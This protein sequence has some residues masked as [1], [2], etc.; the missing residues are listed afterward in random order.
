MGRELMTVKLT[1]SLI[2][3]LHTLYIHYHNNSAGKYYYI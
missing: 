1:E 3:K 2:L